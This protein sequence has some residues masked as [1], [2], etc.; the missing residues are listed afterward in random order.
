MDN[1]LKGVNDMSDKS[2]LGELIKRIRIRM[3]MTQEEFG[4]LIDNSTKSMVSKWERGKTLPNSQRKVI[5]IHLG[6]Q[7]GIDLYP[8]D[9]VE[10]LLKYTERE[11]YHIYGEFISKQFEP[12]DEK[13]QRAVLALNPESLKEEFV[14]SVYP[15]Y[16]E[17]NVSPADYETIVLDYLKRR[18][19][20]QIYSYPSSDDEIMKQ[21]ITDI[22]A[23]EAKLLL[24][25]FM[26][27]GTKYNIEELTIEKYNQ[28]HNTLE[29]TRS[30][31]KIIKKE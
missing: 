5:L 27:D 10:G 23:L 7:V 26:P 17:Q 1:T 14:Q 8:N 6:E 19:K 3:G 31:L 13:F 11:F 18:I 24:Y 29:S 12:S 30:Q 9:E 2:Q 22:E 4:K 16:Y 20:G 25:Y 15:T 21:L 28:L